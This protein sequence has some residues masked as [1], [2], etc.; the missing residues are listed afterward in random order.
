MAVLD[1]S[2]LLAHSKW[3]RQLART[4]V[5]VDADD[6]VQGTWIAALRRP[7]DDDRNVRPWLRK[8]LTNVARLRRRG[9]THRTKREQ[10]AATL[11]EQE[12]P[13]SERL[14]ERHELQQRLARLVG[15]LDEP[16]RS[17]ILLRFAEG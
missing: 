8:V 7:P 12:A 14:L 9:D 3:L 16:Y 11:V 5:H 10:V 13:S 2:E 1:P 15:E 4:L 6:L 17:T